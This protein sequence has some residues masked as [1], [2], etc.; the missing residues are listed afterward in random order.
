MSDYIHSGQTTIPNGSISC[1]T[2]YI[3]PLLDILEYIVAPL[4]HRLLSIAIREQRRS[5]PPS[6]TELDL[7]NIPSQ[8]NSSG[9]F[10]ASSRTTLSDD[11]NYPPHAKLW[12]VGLIPYHFLPEII[13][14]I[15]DGIIIRN[16][17]VGL[18]EVSISY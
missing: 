10:S 14:P 11:L 9:H 6:F 5:T 12:V 13:K 17:L 18:L 4:N 15:V 7:T 1:R 3:A 2:N 16:D 8:R